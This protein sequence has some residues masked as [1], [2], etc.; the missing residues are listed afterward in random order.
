[1][2]ALT[3]ETADMALANGLITPEQ[4]SQIMGTTPEA[5]A[6][7]ASASMAAG[8]RA[9]AAAAEQYAGMAPPVVE[10]PMAPPSP[11]PAAPPA[12]ITNAPAAVTPGSVTLPVQTVT[13]QA[14]PA[15]PASPPGAIISPH[16]A[17]F[18]DQKTGATI[19]P[20]APPADRRDARVI[21]QDRA[22]ELLAEGKTTAR[23][24]GAA[25]E[26]RAA[27]LA[28]T[29]NLAAMKLQAIDAQNN[30]EREKHDQATQAM[31][32]DV[33]QR[34]DEY[35]T[36]TV[37][38]NHWWSNQSTAG[39]IGATLAVALGG[40][41][42]AMTGRNN[43]ALSQINRYVDNDIHA[44]EADIA[45]KRAAAEGKRGVLHDMMQAG[46]SR[47]AA[48]SAARLAALQ[49]V[50][51]QAEAMAAK[52][53]PKF[54][55]LGTQKVLTSIDQEQNKERTNLNFT[56]KH[57]ADQ[58]AAAGAAA[59]AAARLAAQK[60]AA[61][62]DDKAFEH[63]AT[64]AGIQNK[65]RELDIEEKKSSAEKGD[66][67]KESDAY[68]ADMSSLQNAWKSAVATNPGSR[69]GAWVAGALN[70][71]DHSQ[72][73]AAIA[74]LVGFVKGVGDN[75]EEDAKRL[76]NMLPKPNDDQATLDKKYAAL[77][78]KIARKHPSAAAGVTPTLPTSAPPGAK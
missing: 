76:Q 73:A 56:L 17:T 43:D 9:A 28:E 65:K 40:F 15:P 48:V 2:P 19:H 63:G 37:D 53:D 55:R 38:P 14:H 10:T 70:T 4:H 49:N 6:Q 51:M 5:R 24:E 46:Q 64:L 52:Y 54:E 11:P 20:P 42:A 66:V 21:G 12:Y 57:E 35:A 25:R 67:K 33:N 44:Q 69:A 60:H 7:A 58:K 36:K 30:A 1:M 71:D 50:K 18:Y 22:D 16:G 45:N 41:G 34:V 61:E 31:I 72:N 27:D 74:D 75:S 32:S 68:R 3:P 78:M 23:E 77:V 29:Q 59:A 26:A 62:R 8:D 47:E 39:K 13:A